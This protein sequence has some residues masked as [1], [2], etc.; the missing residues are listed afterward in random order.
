[1][2]TL[3]CGMWDL[4]PLSG[5]EPS[6]PPVGAQSLSLWTTR[7]APFFAFASLARWPGEDTPG[8]SNPVSSGLMV[9]MPADSVGHISGAEEGAGGM[10]GAQ[11]HV[12]LPVCSCLI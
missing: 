7:E 3:C 1:M 9:S 10:H 11:G 8:P 2:Q 6:P 12:V 4:V 5:V